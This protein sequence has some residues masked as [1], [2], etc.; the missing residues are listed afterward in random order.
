[1]FHKNLLCICLIFIHSFSFSYSKLQLS[2]MK[3]FQIRNRIDVWV[4]QYKHMCSLFFISLGW[5]DLHSLKRNLCLN[6]TLLLPITISISSFFFFL[7]FLILPPIFLLVLLQL[8]LLLLQ[9]LPVFI[10]KEHWWKRKKKSL[11]VC[12][13][14]VRMKRKNRVD[15]EGRHWRGFFEEIIFLL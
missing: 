15:D 1:V 14:Y 8:L 3:P 13:V 5:L 2:S 10:L 11:Y 4:M 12:Y 6:A 9:L 7:L